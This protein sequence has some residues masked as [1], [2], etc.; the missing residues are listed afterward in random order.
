M[1]QQFRRKYTGSRTIY[2]RKFW[3]AI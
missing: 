2:S 1:E 3:L